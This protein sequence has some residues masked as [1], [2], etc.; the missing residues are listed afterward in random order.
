LQGILFIYNFTKT[1]RFIFSTLHFLTES[2]DRQRDRWTY[3]Y[4]GSIGNGA[5]FINWK[6]HR[7]IWPKGLFTLP[8][9]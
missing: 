1:R 5:D 8:R 4:I 6:R 2:E 3:K 9:E 7:P